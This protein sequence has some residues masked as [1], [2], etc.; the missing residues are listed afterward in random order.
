V[1]AGLIATNAA[2]VLALMTALWVI[3]VVRRDASIVDP[4]WSIAFLVVTVHTV[5]RTGLTPAK[6]LLVVLV[7][8]WAVRLF[9]HLLLRSRGKPEDPRYA[10]FRRRFGAERYWWVSFFQV[11]LLQGA[12]VVLVSA[13]LQLAAA[14]PAPDPITPLH[15]LAAVVFAV[16]FAF[17]AI[18]DRQLQAFRDDPARQGQV[19]DSGLWRWSRHPN[20]FGEALLGWGFWLFGLG[21]PHGWLAVLAPMLMTWLL[22]RVSGVAMLDR[23]LSRTRPGYAAYMERTPGFVPWPRRSPPR[24]PAEPSR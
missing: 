20:Y 4:W 15:V 9:L 11:F 10:A 13:P 12:L 1:S 2:L 24:P 22:L 5:A 6:V 14:A 18:A 23:L 7:A 16:G 17:E 21:Q 8:T 3:S 19:L